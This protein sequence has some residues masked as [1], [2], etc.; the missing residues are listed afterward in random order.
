[1]LDSSGRPAFLFSD[2]CRPAPFPVLLGRARFATGRA[3]GQDVGSLR[4]K[5]AY[6]REGAMRRRTYWLVARVRG[7][8]TDVLVAHLTSGLTALPVF[9]FEEEAELFLQLGAVG[10]G[11]R[12]WEA[13]AGT[14]VS[15]LRGPL[16]EVERVA[17]DPLPGGI[18]TGPLD[19]LASLERERFLGFLS[20]EGARVGRPADGPSWPGPSSG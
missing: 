15:M 1:M 4:K 10:R 12:V 7:G 11:W 16:K 3:L 9:G 13:E 5:G 8:R 6:A 18:G 17:L 19:R 14:L 20:G 2:S